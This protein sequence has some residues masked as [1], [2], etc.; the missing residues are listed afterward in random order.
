MSKSSINVSQQFE[1]LASWGRQI[2]WSKVTTEQVQ[3]AMQNDRSGEILTDLIQNGFE[4]ALE[5]AVPSLATAAAVS[6]LLRQIETFQAGPVV[7]RE[8]H[9]VRSLFD[10]KS[11]VV[12]F[13]WIDP[14]FLAE[15]GDMAI[16]ERNGYEMTSYEL[17]KNSVD[18]PIRA[19]LPA[20][21]CADPTALWDLLVEQPRGGNGHLLVD[22][23]A[24]IF[25]MPNKDGVTRAVGAGRDVFGWCVG[26]CSVG[27]RGEWLRGRR[28]F[29]RNSIA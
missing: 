3:T 19:E 23:S 9:A 17:L 8:P 12:Q 16:A 10:M 22:G 4:R 11:E 28:V 15:F 5:E 6:K 25:Y 20:N 29:S 14:D 26:A 2:D 1:L 13:A 7:P 21:H 24:N 27:G 18:G